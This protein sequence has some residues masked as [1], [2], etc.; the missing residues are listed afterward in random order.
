MANHL[1]EIARRVEAGNALFHLEPAGSAWRVLGRPLFHGGRTV[2]G[3]VPGA[4]QRLEAAL[5]P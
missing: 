5:G 1:R 2:A 3:P 4:S